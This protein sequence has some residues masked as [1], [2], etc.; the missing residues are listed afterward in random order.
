MPDLTYEDVEPHN[1]VQAFAVWRKWKFPRLIR[2]SAIAVPKE[3]KIRGPGAWH[4]VSCSQKTRLGPPFFQ[5]TAI[6]GKRLDG[7]CWKRS[8]EEAIK[9]IESGAETYYVN[10]NGLTANL[11]VATRRGRKY[12]RTHF[13]RDVPATLLGL[14]DCDTDQ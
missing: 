5:L 7:S 1:A 9:E 8:T 12:L 3:R 10:I 2:W 6:G 14:P 4:L 13:D 11:I